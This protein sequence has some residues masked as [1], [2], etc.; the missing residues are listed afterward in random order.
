MAVKSVRFKLANGEFIDLSYEES[1]GSWKGTTT[2][3]VVTSWGE[4]NHKYGAVVEATDDAGNVTT[5]DRTNETLGD[6]LQLRV[7]EKGLP[8]ITIIA[9]AKD[10]FILTGKPT[11]SFKVKDEGSGIDTSKIVLTID[12][13]P[14]S[15]ELDI[16]PVL[17]GD[18]SE[19]MVTYTPAEDLSDGDHTYTISATD[20]DGNTATSEETSFRIDTVDPE[21]NVS[22]PADNTYTN[23]DTI[24]V[25]G[26][27]SDDTSN[28]VTVTV[29]GNTV[30]VEEGAFST[31][32]SL[33]EGE[34]TITVV[35][36]D[37][38]GRTTT[39]VRHVVKDT[40]APVITSVLLTPNPVDAGATYLV[41]VVVE[42][43]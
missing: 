14:V 32:V 39:I 28:P 40:K 8:V 18:T 37:A 29:N 23:L 43:E 3:P 21:L 26:T 16:Q 24:T 11:F 25:S 9:P 1:S 2:S 7:L 41:T 42:D 13:E 22:A 10:A 20:N 36:T 19:Y 34:N 17:E 33:D 4:E 15:G 5:V 35:A 6:S 27:T 12:D 38:A 31:E 30:E